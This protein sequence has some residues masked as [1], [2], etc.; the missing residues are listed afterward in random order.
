MK[1]YSLVMIFDS[2]NELFSSSAL[3]LRFLAI[4]YLSPNRPTA[5]TTSASI[6]Y[7]YQQTG[8][9]GSV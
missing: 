6:V 9:R 5:P 1:Q 3:V 2:P 7:S 4:R 8:L